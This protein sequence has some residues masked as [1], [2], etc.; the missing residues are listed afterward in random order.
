ML[1][2]E[3]KQPCM[4]GWPKIAVKRMRRVSYSTKQERALLL[5]AAITAPAQM[6]HAPT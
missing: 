3:H 4:S 1:R 2:I 5:G 6:Q